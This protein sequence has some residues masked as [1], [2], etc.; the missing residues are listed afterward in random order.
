MGLD[1]RLPIG[2]MF[3]AGGLLL[4]VYGLVTKGDPAVYEK[5]LSIDINLWWGLVMAVFGA[6]FLLLA[7]AARK[8]HQ[9]A[10]AAPQ[11]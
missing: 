3:L 5:S 8:A 9:K 11:K 6:I 1:V 10:A 7:I 4:A 2:A